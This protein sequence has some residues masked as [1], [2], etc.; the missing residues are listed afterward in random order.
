MRQCYESAA[1][2][3]TMV[4]SGMSI[5]PP[6]SGSRGPICYSCDQQLYPDSCH[7]IKECSRDE[8]CMLQRFESQVG[9][10]LL[11]SSNCVKPSVCAEKKQQYQSG[12]MFGKRNSRIRIRGK[13]V[14]IET[15]DIGVP[16]K[17]STD[18]EN[19]VLKCCSSDL[20]NADCSGASVV[21]VVHVPQT[22]P[23][24]TTTQTPST[25]SLATSAQTTASPAQTTD[26]RDS[27][28]DCYLYYNSQCNTNWGLQHCRKTCGHCHAQPAQTTDCS[29]SYQDCY[30]YYQTQCNS[31]WG[32]QN[33]RKTCGLCNV[34][35]NDPCIDHTVCY[36]HLHN[37]NEHR[38]WA[39]KNCIRSCNLCQGSRST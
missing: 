21:S 15:V 39:M 20:C 5:P 29:D 9:H 28:N 4:P 26:C 31:T 34:A 30:R 3:C 33:C 6:S 12:I 22:T 32:L 11:Y 35:F 8:V 23:A 7:I 37:C 17:S 19:C 13:D 1:V 36:Q 18:T 24:P 10:D 27:R 38:D 16:S 25:T 2:L 14:E